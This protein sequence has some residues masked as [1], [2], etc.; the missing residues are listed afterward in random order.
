MSG[1]PDESIPV[2]AVAQVVRTR[3]LKGELVADLLTDFPERFESLSKLIAISPE[4][5]REWVELEDHWFQ[6]GRIILKLKSYD[7]V[8]GAAGFVGYELAVPESDRVPLEEGS[9]YEWELQ[10]CRV[11]T[12]SGVSV[13]IADRLLRTG[14]VEMLIVK[15]VDE[16]ELFVPMTATIVLGIDTTLKRILIDPPEGLLEL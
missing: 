11:E 4:G 3:G 14:G 7:D 5:K 12:V 13:G 8:D 10:G 16:R 2:V 6:K 9:F 1:H 15:S